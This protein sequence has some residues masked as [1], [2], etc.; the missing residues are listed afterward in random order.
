MANLSALGICSLLEVQHVTF[1]Y[2]VYERT[3]QDFL[4]QY[5][6]SV[7]TDGLHTNG[8]FFFINKCLF[9]PSLKSS[10]YISFL[11][12]SSLTNV[13]EN[14]TLFVCFLY[15]IGDQ[16]FSSLVVLQV[17]RTADTLLATLQGGFLFCLFFHKTLH[18]ASFLSN[19]RNNMLFLTDDS[20]MELI[21]K[22][23]PYESVIHT[24]CHNSKE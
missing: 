20:R 19:L 12:F 11:P 6:S 5:K 1:L 8:F 14:K 10:T 7:V 4:W 22:L 9:P 3:S 15:L 13:R 24:Q 18:C 16:F 23:G 2:K 17:K 21:N